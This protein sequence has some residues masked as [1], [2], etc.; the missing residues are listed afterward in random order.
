MAPAPPLPLLVCS[1]MLPRAGTRLLPAVGARWQF[2][3]HP[4][5]PPAPLARWP[6]L[7]PWKRLLNSRSQLMAMLG[8]LGRTLP[9]APPPQSCDPPALC[10]LLRARHRV[11]EDSV[12]SR[13][14]TTQQTLGFC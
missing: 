2:R 9:G 7:R 5:P 11:N 13:R 3:A 14:S 8:E 10:Q 1:K 12:H 4:S 6:T